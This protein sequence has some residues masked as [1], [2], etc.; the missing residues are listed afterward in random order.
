MQII[1]LYVDS[2]GVVSM[3]YAARLG[4][5][6]DNATDFIHCVASSYC[7]RNVYFLLVLDTIRSCTFQNITQNDSSAHLA[8][9]WLERIDSGVETYA[10]TSSS[11]LLDC[12]QIGTSNKI[13]HD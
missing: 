8:E 10:N 12:L 9:T 2:L 11:S 13:L 5:A 4:P 6:V 7:S 1:L 3:I